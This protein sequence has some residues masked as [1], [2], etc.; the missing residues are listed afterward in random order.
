MNKV[1]GILLPFFSDNKKLRKHWWHRM[2]LVTSAV[3]SLTS[4]I[5]SISLVALQIGEIGRKIRIEADYYSGK[6]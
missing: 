5:A 2:V 4:M 3:L 1:F 6:K